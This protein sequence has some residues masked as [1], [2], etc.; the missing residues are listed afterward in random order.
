M[1]AFLLE[2]RDLAAIAAVDDVDLRVAVHL[3]HEPDAPRAQ[4]APVAIQHQRRTEINVRLHAIAVEHAARKFHAALVA[5]ERV[6]KILER[7]FAAL[8]AHRAVERV[9]DQEEFEDGGARLDDVR[10]A[11]RDDHPFGA[12]RRA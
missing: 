5:A 3:A 6:R 10:R 1:D 8:V 9:V 11:R 7:T 12:D 2:R 4:D